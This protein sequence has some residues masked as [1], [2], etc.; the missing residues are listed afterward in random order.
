[1]LA[2][3]LATGGCL[4]N[5]RQDYNDFLNRADRSQPDGGTTA[6]SHLEDLT[7]LWFVNSL[8]AGGINLAL[9]MQF[10]MDVNATPIT[11]KAKI[12]LDTQTINDPPVLETQT[13][14]NADGTFILRAEPLQLGPDQLPVD[15]TVDASVILAVLTLSKDAWCGTATGSVAQPLMLDLGGSTFSAMRDDDQM[16]TKADVPEM[17]PAGTGGT[18]DGGPVDGGGGGDLGDGGPVEPMA[19]DLSAVPSV[20]ADISGQWYLNAKLAGN[21]P[22]PLWLTLV[23]IPV[24]PPTPDGGVGPDGGT[25]DGGTPPADVATGGDGGPPPNVSGSLD[26]TIRSA[27]AHPGTP[28]LASFSTTV[29]L[30]GRFQLWIP[31]FEATTGLGPVKASILLVG[32]TQSMDSFCGAGAGNVTKPI[33]LD[34]T[35]TTFGAVRWQG[36]TPAPM[37][38]PSKCP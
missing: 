36:G 9:R 19:P 5:P 7:G 13:T 2:A 30:Q 25:P 6:Q 15:T 10:T 18:M 20:V 32:A 3:L 4:G 23:Y 29:D 12:W 16:L 17:C 33:M 11:L 1:L 34:L 35:G 38:A 26:G 14:V 21:L 31:D 24:T 27:T 22:L 37:N 8:L 28:A